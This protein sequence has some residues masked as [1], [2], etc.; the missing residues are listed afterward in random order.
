MGTKKLQNLQYK[1]VVHFLRTYRMI[2]GYK[3][4]YKWIQ[5]NHGKR[6][7]KIINCW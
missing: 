1:E 3:E 2:N 4:K 6:A 7:G 5:K